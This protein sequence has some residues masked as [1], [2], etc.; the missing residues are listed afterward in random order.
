MNHIKRNIILSQVGIALKNKNFSLLTKAHLYYSTSS[1]S[2]TN[3]HGIKQI[4][5][6]GVGQMGTGIALVAANVAKLPVK[7]FDLFP[8]RTERALSFM[9]NLLEKDIAKERI[10]RDQAAETKSRITIST[11][12]SELSS[13]DFIIE[14]ASENMEI[15]RKLFSELDAITNENT[16]LASNTSSISITKIASTTKKPDKVIGMHFMNPVP[17]MRLVEI[18]PGLT[19]SDHT[20]QVTKKLAISM[21]KTHTISRDAPGFI[22]NRLLMPYINEAVIVLEQE[23]ASR[24]DID[25]TMKLGTNTPMGPLTLADLIGLDTCLAIMKVLHRELGE[26]KYRPAVLLQKY[27]DAGWLGRKTGKGFYDYE[28]KKF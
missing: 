6:V 4:G 8:N 1:L 3:D 26:S 28:K 15:K 10:T 14:A 23:I 9:D 2:A 22:S 5:V 17:V 7:M 16:I 19:T 24:E 21:G 13:A 20:L 18:I 11:S 12:I 27:V 25:S